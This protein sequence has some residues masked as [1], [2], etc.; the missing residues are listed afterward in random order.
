MT[1]IAT[2]ISVC[3]S[4][5]TYIV[6]TTPVVN[7]SVSTNSPISIST[8][9]T[10]GA[11]MSRKDL[12]IY[13][14]HCVYSYYKDV[15]GCFMFKGKDVFQ[16]QGCNDWYG[17][18]IENQLYCSCAETLEQKPVVSECSKDEDY[19]KPYCIGMG[20]SANKPHCYISGG[21]PLLKCTDS[22]MGKPDFVYYNYINRPATSIVGDIVKTLGIKESSWFIPLI[23]IIALFGILFIIYIM[24]RNK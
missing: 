15:N 24:N 14:L 6:D 9:T 3:N 23:V 22:E 11:P 5:N 7:S 19:L 8:P 2:I 1:V 21:P 10:T 12:D 20:K 16:I 17:Q 18:S 4:N 13:L